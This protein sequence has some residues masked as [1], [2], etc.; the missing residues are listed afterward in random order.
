M[1]LKTRQRACWQRKYR[2]S[3]IY[4]MLFRLYWHG[5]DSVESMEVL[6]VR[7]D[8]GYLGEPL[9]LEMQSFPVEENLR[10][11]WTPKC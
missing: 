6:V 10:K 4:F 8:P 5:A 3:E 11:R 1:D 9:D 7:P 2:D